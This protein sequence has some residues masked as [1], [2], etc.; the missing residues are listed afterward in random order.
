MALTL[1]IVG[2]SSGTWGTILNS[3]LTEMDGR[4]VSNTTATTA[5]GTSI[6]TINGQI[7]TI[8][9]QIVTINGKVAALEAKPPGGLIVGNSASLPAVAVGQITLA[10]D[11]GY[12]SYGAS[13]SG[14]PTRVPFPGSWVGTLRQ[15]VAQSMATGTNVKISFDI[16]EGD[17]LGGY[18]TG[19]KTRYTCQV[20]GT[21]EFSGGVSWQSN[22]TGYRKTNLYLNNAIASSNISGVNAISG[23]AT[24]CDVRTTII[25]MNV[26]DYVELG[27]L[28]NAGVAVNTEVSSSGY[29]SNLSVKYLGYNV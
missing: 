28:H 12:L 15:T 19:A 22:A 3:T 26:G 16:F 29:F 17:R 23:V 13:I 18:S 25:K 10:T 1:P 2:N 20:R 14:V 24:S 21:Y 8:N 11:T 27:A 4:L 5:N 6:T 7:V 9:G